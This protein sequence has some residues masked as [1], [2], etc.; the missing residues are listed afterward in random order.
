LQGACNRKEETEKNNNEN[1]GHL[2]LT[3]IFN[4]K[5]RCQTNWRK[6]KPS[7]IS[8]ILM[9]STNIK[10]PKIKES[11]GADAPMLDD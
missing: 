2:D 10:Q 11:G 1:G 3:M 8:T 4:D 5:S 7:S 6:H 9:L